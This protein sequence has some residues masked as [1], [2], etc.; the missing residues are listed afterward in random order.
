MFNKNFK[1]MIICILSLVLSLTFVTPVFSSVR[2]KSIEDVESIDW[3]EYVEEKKEED[4]PLKFEDKEQKRDFVK[5]YNRMQKAFFGIKAKRL[6]SETF[7]GYDY[8]LVLDY[9]MRDKYLSDEKKVRLLIDDIAGLNDLYNP[10]EETLSS[11]SVCS[12]SDDSDGFNWVRFIEEED[13]DSYKEQKKPINWDL[14]VEDQLRTNKPL[15]L[16]AGKQEES[17]AE[18][19]SETFTNFFGIESVKKPTGPF[20]SYD[21]C[22][23][24][25]YLLSD[26]YPENNSE[27]K[28]EEAFLLINAIADANGLYNPLKSVPEFISEASAAFIVYSEVSEGS[29]DE[30]IDW[31]QYESDQLKTAVALKFQDEAQKEKFTDLYREMCMGLFHMKC[32]RETMDAFCTYDYCLVLDYMMSEAYINRASDAK[33]EAAFLLIDAIAKHNELYNPLED[34]N[35]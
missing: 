25:D 19:Y 26:S 23:V 28:Y 16:E 8:C 3:E 31:D 11:F 1:R 2:L 22:L 30:K 13:S 10:L 7:T 20:T 35:N 6:E 18:L 5:L 32:G 24:V 34:V 12:E 14:Y 21:Y 29:G 15:V 17:F 33:Y 27:D 4:K 9:V